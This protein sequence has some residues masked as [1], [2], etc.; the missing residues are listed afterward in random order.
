MNGTVCEPGHSSGR[1]PRHLEPRLGAPAAAPQPRPAPPS[2]PGL[3]SSPPA[4][5]LL[6]SPPRPSPL[7]HSVPVP[8]FLCVSLRPQLLPVPPLFSPP[9]P[10]RLP[11]PSLPPSLPPSALL[12]PPSLAHTHPRLGLL[13]LSGSIFSAAGGRGLLW[14]A[15]PVPQVS[16]RGGGEPPGEPGG[17]NGWGL[18]RREQRPHRVWGWGSN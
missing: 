14:G 2:R 4:S 16:L 1:S 8:R 12:P 3:R 10:P 18:G 9:L 11:S 7:L 15:Q 6:P 13:S 5:S 17:G